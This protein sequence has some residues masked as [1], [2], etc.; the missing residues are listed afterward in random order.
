TKAI[1]D[2]ISEGKRRIF[3]AMATGTG[4]TYTM[5]SE[6]YRL[7]TSGAAK[8]ILFLVDRR[9]LAAQAVVAFK[10]FEPVP[11]QKFD[12]IY[13]V[14]S[15]SF[16][17]EDLEDVKKINL[18][19]IPENYLTDPKPIH[20][21]VYVS[22]IQRMRINLFG[23]EGAFETRKD[24]P[25]EE[26]DAAKQD[27]PINAFD[28]IIADECHRGYTALEESKW[29]E[30]LDYFDAITIGLTA[31]PASH[32]VAH[33]G[34]P[35]YRYG[36][37]EAVRD[38]Y[39]VD[40]DAVAIHSDVRMKGIF[41]HEGE[42]VGEIDP[43]TGLE[44]LDHLEDER[45][46]DA[47][48]IEQRITSP[49]SNRKIVEEFKK[50][51]VEHENECGR[52]P[53]TL[54]FA[55]NDLQPSM[56]HADQL[57][58]IC[59]KAFPRGDDFV[60]KITGNPTV[61]RPLQRIREFRNRPKPGIVVTV[62]MLSTG[63]DIPALEAIVFL[64][65]VKSR[66]LFEQMIGRGTRKCDEIEKTHFTVFDCFG[67]TLFEYFR[68]VSAFTIDPPLKPTRPIQ[69]IVE[70]IFQNRN[71]EYN[72]RVLIKRFHRIA[73]HMS[74]EAME[75]FASFIPDGDLCK[76]AR[77]LPRMLDEDFPQ[78]IE[79]LKN[80]DF[81]DLLVS[82]P[83]A[84][85]DFLIA[86]DTKDEVASA[87]LIRQVD[88]T[89]KPEDYVEAFIR[90]VRKNRNNVVAIKI[91][92]ERPS[93]WS[94]EALHELRMALKSG[95]FSEKDLR[96]AYHMELAD[97]I[98]LIKHAAGEEEPLLT[99]EERVKNALDRIMKG[100]EFNE[101]QLHWLEIIEAHLIENLS[102]DKEDF[103]RMPAFSLRGGWNVADRAFD[104]QLEPLLRE[105]NWAVA[106]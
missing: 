5:V 15:Q 8:R 43:Q 49:D 82:Y 32:T 51:V 74:G 64:R 102:I 50:Y 39:L 71:R 28:V 99:A 81:Q 63:V 104:H 80:P 38:G 62:D 105:I 78:M 68:S 56:S 101:Q 103:E 11:R 21:Y 33:F 61:D 84:K 37:E 34:E 96:K 79:K 17:R 12:Q 83:R 58:R 106:S 47:S 7:M 92:L 55:T 66:I 53:K 26:A 2:A 52:F 6:A 9:A 94:T 22:T 59:R 3:V 16:R 20:A 31:T 57:V 29:R 25:E 100:K 70:D 73:K 90:F 98:S 18:R 76:F 10:T 60:Q 54:I 69:E 67:G 91:L 40:Y 35:V 41:L 75:R 19:V 23:R 44:E 65:P 4:K 97:I 45:Y 14:Y 85:R 42:R 48:Q 72:M 93:D 13:E 36:Y 24:E 27:I 30:V 77:D 95:G 1:E 46:F 86:Y 88:A 89:Q 87:W